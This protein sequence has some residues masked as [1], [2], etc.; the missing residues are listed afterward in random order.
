MLINY[1]CFYLPLNLRFNQNDIPK[2]NSSTISRNGTVEI[3]PISKPSSRKCNHA[4]CSE[5]ASPHRQCSQHV[6]SWEIPFYLHEHHTGQGLREDGKTAHAASLTLTFECLF[7]LAEFP[8]YKDV[9][10]VDNLLARWLDMNDFL[11]RG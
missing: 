3:W 8:V 2:H 11:R 6:I 1:N 9:K 5:P 4:D 7:N 10:N